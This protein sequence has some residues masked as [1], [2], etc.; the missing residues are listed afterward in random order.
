MGGLISLYG[1]M[2]FAHTFGGAGVFS[3]SL[4]LVPN[5]T[6]EL[7]AVAELNTQ[8]PQRYYF[9]GGSKEGDNMVANIDKVT[10]FLKGFPHYQ[11][12]VEIHDDGE[13]SEE[14]WRNKFP[15][16]YGWLSQAIQEA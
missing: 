7:K 9:Y 2:H 8:F 12:D 6:E 1:A 3:P 10:N 16:Y 4:W 14:H 13:H 11:V 5:V 15:D